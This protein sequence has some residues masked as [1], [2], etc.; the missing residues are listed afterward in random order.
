MTNCET[1][2]IEWEWINFADQKTNPPSNSFLSYAPTLSSYTI[3]TQAK[4]ILI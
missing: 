1:S 4:Y 2:V 3:L